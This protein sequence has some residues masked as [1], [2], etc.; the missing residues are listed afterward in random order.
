MNLQA[1]QA[2][3]NRTDIYRI[4]CGAIYCALLDLPMYTFVGTI[5]EA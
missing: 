1:R 4:P 2:Q 3:R 5:S